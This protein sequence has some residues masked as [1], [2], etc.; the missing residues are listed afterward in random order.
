M[1]NLR[2]LRAS[3][4][5]CAK[6]SSLMCILFSLL[7]LFSVEATTLHAFHISK[8]EIDVTNSEINIT[9]HFFIDDFERALSQS[10]TSGLNL[11]SDKE[12]KPQAD[13]AVFN[14]IKS[15]FKII[16]NGKNYPMRWIGKERAKDYQ[17]MYVYYT[18]EKVKNIKS[19]E[20]KPTL[21]TETFSDQKNIVEIKS[22]SKK[23][24]FIIFDKSHSSELVKF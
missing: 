18:I 24:G 8:T 23:A 9:T 7:Y 10:G 20:L 5:L 11:C 3:L 17:A 16:V 13:S 19:L 21:L 14:Y 4:R 1:V 2:Y 12:K 6:F 22:T 15:H